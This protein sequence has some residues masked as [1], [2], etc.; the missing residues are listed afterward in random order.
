M[1]K[2]IVCVC[3]GRDYTNKQ[4]V[5]ETLDK[6][7]VVF[8]N[9]YIINGGAR[10]A[11]KISTSWSEDMLVNFK[12]FPAGWKKHPIAAGPIRNRE[13]LKYGFNL[14]IAF[15]GGRGTADMV[16]ITKNAGIP[17]REIK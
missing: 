16:K 2:F 1:N 7:L 15:S 9:L 13:M 14:L 5:Y 17:V 4:K 10:G 6:V 8:P 11:D 3:G 12:E